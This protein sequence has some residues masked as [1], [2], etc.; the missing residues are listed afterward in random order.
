MG[1]TSLH[2]KLHSGKNSKAGY[3][4]KAGFR[5][6]LPDALFRGRLQQE[7]KACSKLYDDGY[8]RNRVDYYCKLVAPT[9]LGSEATVIKDLS[10]KDSNSTYYFDSRELLQWFDPTLRWNHLFGDIVHIPPYPTVV[11]SR[12][13]EGD[14]SNSV[15]LKLDKCRH[16]VYVHDR[17][18]PEDKEDRAIF[19]GHIG[20]RQNRALFCKMFADNPRIDAADTI[21]SI[22]ENSKTTATTKPMLSFYEHLRFRYIMALE[23]NDVASNLKWIMSSHSAAVMPKPTCETW[24]MEGRLQPGIHY[25]EVRPDFT[26]LEE[27]MDYYSAHLDEL[28]QIVHNANQ[29]VDQFRDLRRER[30]IGLLT[31]QKYFNLTNQ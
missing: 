21:P 29:Y 18:R 23:G 31:L 8:C 26:D 4:L 16:F 6:I 27:K 13:L 2:Y 25:I 17:L 22:T 20:S 28:N 24:Y 15:M 19:R 14:N 30:Y 1:G 5:D 11:K 7:M 12:P 3:Y 10:L 9:S